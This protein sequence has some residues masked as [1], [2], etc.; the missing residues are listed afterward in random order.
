[1]DPC[2]CMNFIIGFKALKCWKPFSQQEEKVQ[3]VLDGGGKWE[4][5]QKCSFYLY[6]LTFYDHK[7]KYEEPATV[8]NDLIP[9]PGSLG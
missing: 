3:T 4:M 2:L 1:M 5:V 9:F 6:I 7:K 8:F